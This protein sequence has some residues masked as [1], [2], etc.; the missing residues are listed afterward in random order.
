MSQALIKEETK[1]QSFV[2]NQQEAS[3]KQGWEG[4]GEALYK[5]PSQMCRQFIRKECRKR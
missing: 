4:S 2:V 1:C 3:N 5:D